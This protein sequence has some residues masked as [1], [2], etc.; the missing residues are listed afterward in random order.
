MSLP[1]AAGHP[2]VASDP[3]TCPG[4]TLDD[5]LVPRW[6]GRSKDWSQPYTA[7]SRSAL[8]GHPINEVR[9]DLGEDPAHRL[10]LWGGGPV[11]GELNALDVPGLPKKTD[12]IAVFG[13]CPLARGFA[14]SIGG[15][16]YSIRHPFDEEG[17]GPVIR[18]PDMVEAL[19]LHDVVIVWISAT[20]PGGQYADAAQT[21]RALEALDQHVVGPLQ[22]VL[23]AYR[24]ARGTLIAVEAQAPGES[25]RLSGRMPLLQW[26]DG[27]SSDQ[28]GT[29]HEDTADSGRLG[30]IPIDAFLKV[31]W[32]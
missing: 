2:D 23:A 26:G 3:G 22:D 17:S 32:S 27:L 7:W 20:G 29:W 12:R 25:I 18:V 24:P 10:W 16:S 21:V 31:V 11:R 15:G 14:R 19:R 8:A 13:S 9:V 1:E 4:W 30:E 5:P 28:L 6:F